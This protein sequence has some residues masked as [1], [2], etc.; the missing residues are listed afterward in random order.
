M[1]SFHR[2]EQ[3]LEAYYEKA[4]V[5]YHNVFKRCGLDALI[6]E[7]SGGAFS[8]YS[9]EFQVLTEA[10]EDTV[11]YCMAC[12]YAQNKEI[13]EI[14]TGDACPKC[15][16]SI[17]EGKAIEV[18]NIFQLKTRFTD[19]FDVTFADEDGSKKKVSMGCYGIGP[20]RVMGAIAEV[21]HDEKGIVWPEGVAPFVAHIIPVRFDDEA[22]QQL[23]AD[24]HD[25]LEAAGISTLLDD[26]DRQAGE[27]FADAD[28]LGAPYRSPWVDA[29]GGW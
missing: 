10:G 17:A 13:A 28:L 29:R 20:S 7:A 16:G 22:Q 12:R 1:Y 15:G 19:A 26:R 6:V 11:Y 9:H 25:Q 5:A 14:K 8:K 23:A 4:K 24:M 21:H 27:K 18:G 3:D 2:D